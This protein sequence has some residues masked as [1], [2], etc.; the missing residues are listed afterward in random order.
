M[1]SVPKQGFTPPPT[2]AELAA[3]AARLALT[4]PKD[5]QVLPPET[6]EYITEKDAE[7]ALHELIE[8]TCDFEGVD[9]TEAMP[10]NM[11]GCTLLPHQI[12]G[13]YWL[14]DRES[15]KNYGGILADVSLHSSAYLL[16][17]Y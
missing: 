3:K 13:V 11:P 16:F 14:K 17:V 2:A 7:K 4:T 1:I 10:E 8:A 12:Q 6:Y 5:V 15:K 9:M